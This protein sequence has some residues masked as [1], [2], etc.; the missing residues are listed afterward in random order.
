MSSIK[1]LSPWTITKDQNRENEQT[2]KKKLTQ[3]KSQ[4]NQNKSQ[5]CN[6]ANTSIPTQTDLKMRTGNDQKKANKSA[7][8][9]TSQSNKQAQTTVK[10][11]QTYTTAITQGQTTVKLTQTNTA[12]ITQKQTHTP[13][14]NV[15][16]ES[17]NDIKPKY[18]TRALKL[19]KEGLIRISV[20][21]SQ[22]FNKKEMLK[23]LKN[24]GVVEVLNEENENLVIC[25]AKTGN[26]TTTDTA[27]EPVN[28]IFDINADT[29]PTYEEATQ[30]LPHDK[31]LGLFKD[32]YT[33][34]EPTLFIDRAIQSSSEDID[35]TLTTLDL[36][37]SRSFNIPELIECDKIYTTIKKP[38][39]VFFNQNAFKNFT[40]CQIPESIAIILSFG[41]KFSLPIY[42]DK[43]DFEKLRDAAIQLNDMYSHPYDTATIRMG[44]NK[45]IQKYQKE[46]YEQHGSEIRDYF[47]AALG[48]TR[49]FMKNTDGII[50]TQADKA[51]AAIVMNKDVYI[52]KVEK[53]LSDRSTYAPL[54]HSSSTAYQKINAKLLDKFVKA[55]MINKQEMQAALM[56]ET[57]TAN[58]YALIKTHKERP[59]VNTKKTPGYLAANMITKILTKGRDEFKYNVFNS[60]QAVQK[61][62]N[63]VILPDEKFASFDA[64][65][66]FTNIT[67]EEAI[68]SITWLNQLPGFY[69]V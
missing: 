48:E 47:T 54:K 39:N 2:K 16:V 52:D 8:T 21:R 68:K 34:K 38:N 5:T 4:T 7:N 3:D 24:M 33:Q 6:S 28:S 36:A 43:K 22:A 10:P 31:D 44:I 61:I 58:M 19:K 62:R 60:T 12:T 40:T 45:H 29:F 15:K 59:I 51:N 18:V 32:A 69:Y 9:S 42:Y 65:S 41:P 26:L 55:E 23:A 37:F 53:L 25:L 27:I 35:N 11:T 64:K 56:E 49:E 63:A 30:V 20:H 66:M 17:N 1:K 14:I 57:R 13:V 50:I 46:Q 67:T